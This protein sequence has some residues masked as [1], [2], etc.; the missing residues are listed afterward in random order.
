MSAKEMFGALGYEQDLNNSYNIGYF[1]RVTELRIR[2]IT[3][4]KDYKYMTFIDSDNNCSITLQELQAIN[5]QIEELG[6]LEDVKD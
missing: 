2:T 6:W 5:K 1:K 3:F 4:I